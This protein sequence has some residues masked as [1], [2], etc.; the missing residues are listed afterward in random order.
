MTTL[1]FNSVTSGVLA[2]IFWMISSPLAAAPQPT[3]DVPL[4]D[5][6]KVQNFPLAYVCASQQLGLAP[7]N[8]D[9]LLVLAR[10]AQEL[11]QF[12]LADSLAQKARG[13]NLNTGQRFA[14][15]LI[16]GMAQANQSKLLTAKISLYRASDFARAEPEHL[17]I[18]FNRLLECF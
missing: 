10:A 1:R 11:G 16:S 14:A 3:C 15:H 18:S 17:L 5:I 4:R 12:A 7:Q 6:V 2:L 13:Y 8:I 9:A